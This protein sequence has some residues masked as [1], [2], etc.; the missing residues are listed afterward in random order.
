[1]S[2]PVLTATKRSKEHV[3]KKDV[4]KG[5]YGELLAK[6]FLEKFDRVGAIEDKSGVYE[7]QKADVDLLVEVPTRDGLEVLGV[8]VKNDTTTYPNLFYETKSVIK[9]EKV[10][11]VGCLLVS[12]ADYLIYIYQAFNAAVLVPLKNLN[13]WVVD[14]LKTGKTFGKGPVYNTQ[15]EGEGYKIPVRAL[16]G[17]AGF[18]KVRQLQLVDLTTTKPISY[19]EFEKR[20]V[21]A[22][23]ETDGKKY[24]KVNLEKEKGWEE[25]NRRLYPNRNKLDIVLMDIPERDERSRKKLEYLESFYG[26][27]II[28]K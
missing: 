9:G 13:N 4:V 16:A 2:R 24:T 20:R 3:M 5:D 12:E 27:K 11:S 23:K 18:K 1:M 7:Y 8:E 28:W 19:A 21:W 22:D 15:Y 10:Q 17:E 25:I 6:R 26:Q 14:Y